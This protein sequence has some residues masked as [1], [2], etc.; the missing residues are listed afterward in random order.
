MSSSDYRV[1]SMEL[2]VDTRCKWVVR[3]DLVTG[4]VA[5]CLDL[6]VAQAEQEFV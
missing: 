1:E 6:L 3:Y 4:C 5:V 2:I